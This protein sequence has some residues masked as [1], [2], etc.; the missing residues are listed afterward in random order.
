M[1]QVQWSLNNQQL[2]DYTIDRIAVCHLNPSWRNPSGRNLFFLEDRCH[3]FLLSLEV[4]VVYFKKKKRVD[5]KL[6][7]T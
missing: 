3:R 4:L 6:A 1:R 7:Q 5:E 2:I